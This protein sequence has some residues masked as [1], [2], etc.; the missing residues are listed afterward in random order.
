M[1][2][3]D[4]SIGAETELY[5]RIVPQWVVPDHTRGCLRLSSAAFTHEERSIVLEDTLRDSG[6]EPRDALGAYP[7]EYLASLTAGFV[8]QHEQIVIRSPTDD[9]PAHG[10]VIGSKPKS[11]RRILAEATRWIV[12]PDGA[13]PD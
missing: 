1:A 8:R 7:G 12:A 6:R 9:E 5:R 11:R 10:E 2:V 4:A 3:D 13:C